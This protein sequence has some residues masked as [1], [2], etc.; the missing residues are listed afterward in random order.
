MW[1]KHSNKP[2]LPSYLKELTFQKICKT[3][4]VNRLE[5]NRSDVQE[6]EDKWR[7]PYQCPSFLPGESS[8]VVESS[9]TGE[10]RA[11]AS[12]HPELRRL[13]LESWES[14]MPGVCR[15]QYWRGEGHT[16]K[17]T[18]KI[19]TWSLLSIKL[20]SK[21]WVCVRRLHEARKRTIQKD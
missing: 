9:H 7:E 1:T 8:Q 3:M 19:Y 12:E 6:T 10:T 15:A 5:M 16:E 18:T 20:S 14:K 13:P 11:Q 21:Q 17:N 4:V 2:D